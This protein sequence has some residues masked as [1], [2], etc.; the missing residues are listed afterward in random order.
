MTLPAT[1]FKS[2]T[3]SALRCCAAQIFIHRTK[4]TAHK[5]LFALL[6][7]AVHSLGIFTKSLNESCEV[8]LGHFSPSTAL[9]FLGFIK[10]LLKILNVN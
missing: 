5:N 1:S 3:N 10:W 2:S 6:T 7:E 4:S 9:N 8:T